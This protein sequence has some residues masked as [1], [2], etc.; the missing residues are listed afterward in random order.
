MISDPILPDFES[1][2][3]FKLEKAPLELV[4]CQIRFTGVMTLEPSDVIPFQKAIKKQYPINTKGQELDMEFL[5]GGTQSQFTQRNVT[6]I[7]NFADTSDVWK[8]TLT[9]DYIALETR[10]Y[11]KFTEFLNRLRFVLD[12]LIDHIQPT[13]GTR[14][15]LRY[16][17]EIR[18]ESAKWSEVIQPEILGVAAV[19]KLMNKAVNTQ[20][21]QVLSL[22]L[23]QK[24]GINIQHGIFPTGTTVRPLKQDKPKTESFY[25][26]DFDV[27]QEYGSPDFLVMDPEIIS[28]NVTRFHEAI[29]QMFLWA[30]N[31][32]YLTKL[33]IEYDNNTI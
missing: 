13:F 8:I 5:A 3:R 11:N 4:I 15:G 24:R 33:G 16:I 25:L 1:V 17:D 22:T 6:P 12:A 28:E 14:I 7:Y 30:V 20:V 29:D 31:P 19:P 2:K 21:V 9:Q 10:K 32:D 18:F 27:F 23:P 26:L